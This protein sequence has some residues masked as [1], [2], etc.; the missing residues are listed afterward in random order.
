MK[1]LYIHQH[2]TTPDGSGGTRS[3]EFAKA[4]VQAGHEVTMVCG[5]K[6]L[7]GYDLPYNSAQRWSRGMVEGID[8]ISLPMSYSNHDS[9]AKRSITFMLFAWHSIYFAMTYPCDLIFATS[10]PL[11][12]SIPGIVAKLL[13]RKCAFVF[14]V[15][16]LWPELPWALGMRNPFLLSG[17]WCLEWLAY[18]AADRC[19]GLSPGI[20][21]GIR[22]RSRANQIVTMI[23]NACDLELF[24]P[25]K[26]EPLSLP[27]VNGGDFVAAFTGTT[28]TA[29]GLDI[30]IDVAA[31]LKKLEVADI[32]LVIIGD[33][34][35]KKRLVDRASQSG[36]DNCVF[37]DPLAKSRLANIVASLGCGLM[38]L[39][40][41]PA[42]YYG[43]SPNKFFD[44]IS[45]GIPVLNNY[46]G[47]LADLITTHRCGLVVPPDDPVAFAHALIYLRDHPDERKEMAQRARQL[48]EQ[49]FSRKLLGDAFVRYLE[50]TV[51]ANRRLDRAIPTKPC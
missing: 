15:R 13:R 5:A 43:T 28:G 4:L 47:W 17:M 19:V 36:L 14:E 51:E 45:S 8:V 10:T 29:N 22:K 34:N 48:A 21:Q 20:V 1:V 12:A 27:G 49:E 30:V 32:K 41:V 38:I 42:F 39:K 6:K 7:H 26:R 35:Q 44:Y 33:G 25:S 16:D 18:R 46:P 3:Y 31:Q 37:I 24:C 50:E 23:P 11:S 2:F 40:N 9:I